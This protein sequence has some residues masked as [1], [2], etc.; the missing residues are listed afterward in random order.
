[1]KTLLW[2]AVACLLSSCA[3]KV[4]VKD[5]AAPGDFERDRYDCEMVATQAAANWGMRGNVFYIAQE[6]QKCMVLKHGWRQR[7]R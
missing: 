5:G 7:S 6:T 1:M 2:L 3:P 4:F